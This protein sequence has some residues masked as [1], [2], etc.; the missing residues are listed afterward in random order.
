MQRYTL[1]CHSCGRVHHKEGHGFMSTPL[2]V[3]LLDAQGKQWMVPMSGCPA[4]C[5]TPGAIRKAYTQG[6][7][8]EARKRAQRE[9][10]AF[11]KDPQP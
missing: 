9:W 11:S 4:C 5:A 1:V 6:M 8:P 2:S 7:T 3:L 10:A